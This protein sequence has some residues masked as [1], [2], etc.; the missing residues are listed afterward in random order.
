MKINEIVCISIHAPLAGSDLP[1]RIPFFRL[2]YFNPRSPRGE[3]RRK[4]RPE[5]I[6]N[7]F[8]PRSP[9]GE[10]RCLQVCSFPRFCDFN[11][12]SPRGERQKSPYRLK[13]VKKFQ[14]TLPS[15]GATPCIRFFHPSALNFNP[16][17]PRGE[18]QNT[19]YYIFYVSRIS[20]HAPLAGS[21]PGVAAYMTD[22]WI[23]IHAPLAG[24]D[25]EPPVLLR[26]SSNISIHAPLAGSDSKNAQTD[27]TFLFIITCLRFFV[28]VRNRITIIFY[29]IRFRNGMFKDQFF[30]KGSANL[31]DI[32]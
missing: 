1:I 8:N 4:T 3:R 13:A 18:R 24:S 28:P 5:P 6:A 32:F 26:T 27:F 14:S 23:S 7:Y 19:G 29:W 11:P 25:P 31:P 12:R 20:I 9:R 21:D 17:S 10:R 30:K 15:R 2:A 22:I 16:R